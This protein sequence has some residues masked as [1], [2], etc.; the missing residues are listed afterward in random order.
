MMNDRMTTIAE[1]VTPSMETDG[2]TGIPSPNQQMRASNTSEARRSSENGP[3]IYEQEESPPVEEAGSS[4]DYRT[5][6]R[7]IFLHYSSLFEQKRGAPTQYLTQQKFKKFLV[8]C[9]ILAS[10]DGSGHSRNESTTSNGASKLRRRDIDGIFASLTQTTGG[11]MTFDQFSESL[12]IISKLQFKSAPQTEALVALYL[13]YLAPLHHELCQTT[14][15]GQDHL[16]F[17]QDMEQALISYVQSI[18]NRLQHVYLSYFMHETNNKKNE[19][20]ESLSLNALRTFV[21]DFNL[22][23]DFIHMF[24]VTSFYYRLLNQPA[25]MLTQSSKTA[26][27][28]E[29]NLVHKDIGISF[30]FARFCA[31]LCRI[32]ILFALKNESSGNMQRSMQNSPAYSALLLLLE[33]MEATP[34]F[35]IIHK[36]RH[37]PNFSLTTSSLDQSM[38]QSLVTQEDPFNDMVRIQ[39]TQPNS[40]RPNGKIRRKEKTLATEEQL[41]TGRMETQTHN[42][43]QTEATGTQNY[44]SSD[45]REKFLDIFLRYAAQSEPDAEG[46]G[47]GRI[48]ASAQ[49]IDAFLRDYRLV[50]FADITSVGEKSERNRGL[51]DS[52]AAQKAERESDQRFKKKKE[53]SSHFT[54]DRFMAL[55]SD[56]SRELFP[57]L[58][59][60]KRLAAMMNKLNPK[61]GSEL[62][63]SGDFYLMN[64]PSHDKSQTLT[65]NFTE[66]QELPPGVSADEENPELITLMKQFG[67]ALQKCGLFRH[68]TNGANSLNNDQFLKLCLDLGI[69][70]SLCPYKNL[71][72]IYSSICDGKVMDLTKF[73]ES[74]VVCAMNA[75]ALQKHQSTVAKVHLTWTSLTLTLAV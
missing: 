27:Q 53:A 4:E 38:R 46:E 41:L 24:Q 11:K 49:E 63:K 25:D 45:Q 37:I 5:I 70:P 61:E 3:A 74:I 75:E 64:A 16:V 39:T 50:S 32:S 60:S 15:L 30:T 13:Y 36:K 8:D 17:S 19:T 10:N 18:A 26:R 43:Q 22:Q 62:L 33:R 31:F 71:Q 7:N 69:F 23:T 42:R 58:D 56:L 47:E 20:I 34:S 14:L 54:F 57:D 29:T 65:L 67:Q 9:S 35:E 12:M 44:E 52:V 1:M 6:L 73:A 28:A 59:E 55:L 21:K 68:Y 51:A 48:T 2:N 72:A 66:S 40:S